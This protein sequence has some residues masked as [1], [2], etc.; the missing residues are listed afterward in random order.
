[1]RAWRAPN[2]PAGVVPHLQCDRGLRGQDR[3]GSAGGVPEER[4][5]TRRGRRPTNGSCRRPRRLAEWKK[6][7]HPRGDSGT[8]PVKRGLGI[9]VNAWGGGGHGSKCA[10]HH[11]P[12]RLGGGGNGHA[13][14]GHGH[15]HHHHAGGRGDVRPADE[16]G[17]AEDRRQR[18]IRR[19]AL[20]RFDHGWRR[21]SRPRAKRRST[22]W[23]SCSRPSPRRSA[24]EPD[25]LEAVDGQI[26]VKGN[27]AKSLTWKAACQKLGV[28]Q[29]LGDGRER[30]SATPKEGSTRAASAACRSRCLRGYRN[31]HREDEQAGGGA[32]LRPDHQSEAGGEPDLSARCIMGICGAL[33]EE[34]IIDEHHRARVERRHGVLQAGRIGDI[35]EIVVHLDIDET[36]TSAAS[37][38]WANRPRS[39]CMPPSPTRWPTPSACGCLGSR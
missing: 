33:M 26:Q 38:G 20:G 24:L 25:Q 34:R 32:G 5:R 10:L 11:Q 21:L 3:D 30:P 36:M 12:G 6:L 4:R 28:K 13:G 16:R 8:G 31:G 9:G 23:T 15:T 29:D 1:M 39:A 37:S 22:R 27:P 14:P 18:T 17:Q 35:G 2:N 7:W 19:R